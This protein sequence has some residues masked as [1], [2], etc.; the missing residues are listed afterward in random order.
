MDKKT[1]TGL[2]LM[3]VVIV[4]SVF[5]MRPSE[6]ALK[7]ERALQDSIAHSTPASPQITQQT[8]KAPLLQDSTQTDT[9]S[10]SGPFGQARKGEEQFVTLENELIKAT[11]SSKGGRIKSVELKNEKTYD[12]KPLILFEGDANEFGLQF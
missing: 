1:F 9:V 10:L 5:L 7:K 2:F 6:E 11:I 4:G 8:D 12:G 3:L